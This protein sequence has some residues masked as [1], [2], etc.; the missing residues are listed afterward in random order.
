VELHEPRGLS[1]EQR[2]DPRRERVE[3]PAVADPPSG[4][5]APDERHDIVGG[6]SGGLRDDQDAVRAARGAGGHVLAVDRG[7]EPAGLGEHDRPS[8]GDR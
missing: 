1:Q 5:E 6:G 7:R 8:L 2:Q 3:R 4:R